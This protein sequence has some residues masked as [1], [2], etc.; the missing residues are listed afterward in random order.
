MLLAPIH[1]S[2]PGSTLCRP[3]S[4]TVILNRCSMLTP[5]VLILHRHRCWMWTLYVLILLP[6][7]LL[8]QCLG[9]PCC[10]LSLHRC[11]SGKTCKTGL[12]KCAHINQKWNCTSFMLTCFFIVCRCSSA[13]NK[14]SVQQNHVAE[15]LIEPKLKFWRP[16]AKWKPACRATSVCQ[17]LVPLTFL[18][19]FVPWP[20]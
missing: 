8:C 11:S 3:M 13:S 5:Y 18:L 16:L 20:L 17:S 9:S 2:C 19:C 4:P 12:A 10:C 7:L 15:T 14:R 1:I 6:P